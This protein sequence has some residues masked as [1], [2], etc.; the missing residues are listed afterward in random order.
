M[1]VDVVA[2]RARG[3]AI[4]GVAL[5]AALVVATSV[6]KARVRNRLRAWSRLASKEGWMYIVL[7]ASLGST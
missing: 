7:G 6:P 1:A 2:C 5:V 3:F 4:D